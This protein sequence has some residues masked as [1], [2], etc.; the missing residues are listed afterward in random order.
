V[1]LTGRAALVT[2]AGRRLGQ[3]IAVGLARAGCDVAVHFHRSEAGAAETAAAVAAAGR[4]TALVRGDLADAGIARNLAP[5]VAESLGGRLDVVVS[6]AAVMV[7]QPVEQIT[8]Q[9]WDETLDL[10]LRGAFFVAQGAIPFLRAARGKIVFL[11]DVAAFEPWPNYLP[12]GVSKA[13][14]VLLTRTLARA[15]A[16]EIAVNAVAPGPVL[17]PEDWDQDT[18][19]RF[20]QSTPLARL[21]HPD[22]VVAAVRFLLEGTDFVTGTTLVVDGGRLIR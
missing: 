12:H 1:E 22:D 13:G 17:L 21:G 9:S 5:R 6:S 20:A 18:H 14:L 15:L 3:A 16:P 7:R 11:A 19:A 2:G 8:P 4:R 10:N